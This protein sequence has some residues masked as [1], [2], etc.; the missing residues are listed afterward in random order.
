MPF[1]GFDLRAEVVLMDYQSLAA[2]FRLYFVFS[3][4]LH[5][6]LSQVLL[7]SCR[8]VTN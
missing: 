4:L 5:G 8:D 7:Q 3:H 6:P 2:G 1:Q